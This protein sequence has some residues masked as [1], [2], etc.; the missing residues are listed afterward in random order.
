ML[1]SA[2]GIGSATAGPDPD[3]RRMDKQIR[4]F[5]R[6]MDD[7]LVESPNWLV[8]SA[9]STRGTYIEGHGAVFSFKV[10]LNDNR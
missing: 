8:R 7:M 1:V 6:V 9:E 10:D 2:V 5:E 3:S 4:I